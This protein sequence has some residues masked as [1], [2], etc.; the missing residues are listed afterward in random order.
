MI[1]GSWGRERF[2][3]ELA[4]IRCVCVCVCVCACRVSRQK[5]REVRERRAFQEV[6][7]HVTNGISL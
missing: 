7:L 5:D 2:A 3:G 1:I 6:L 4:S